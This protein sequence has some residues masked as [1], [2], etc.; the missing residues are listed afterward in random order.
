MNNQEEPSVFT[1]FINREL[2]AD[3]IFEND[4][5]IIIKNIHPLAPIHWLGITKEPI[6]NIHELLSSTENK[7]LL[8]GSVPPT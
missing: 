5:V 3:I 8:L 1:R 2:P 4:Q 6:P 7:D